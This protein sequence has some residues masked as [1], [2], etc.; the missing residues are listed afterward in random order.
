MSAANLHAACGVAIREF[1][2]NPGYGF[3]ENLLYVDRKAF[4]RTETAR[5]GY[6]LSG[7]KGL[8]SLQLMATTNQ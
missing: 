7:V 5:V 3:A 6:T 4:G 1:P 2:L 8:W